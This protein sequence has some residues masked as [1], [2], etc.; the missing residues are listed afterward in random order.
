MDLEALCDSMTLEEQVALLAGA[1]FWTTVPIE[2]VGVPAIK[3]T[4]GP[5]G[6]RGGGALLGG[7]KTACFPVGIALA[8][9]WNVDLVHRIGQA[10]A[11]EAH[12]KGA[13][14][15]LG[16]T[17][18]LH[19]HPLNGRNFECFSEDPLLSARVACAYIEGL[20]S[21][22][23]AATVK[24]YAG[25]ESEF[26]R[27]TINSEIDER[28][29][30]E[31]YLLPFEAAV[32][33]AGT[34]AVMA[35][36]NRLN[37][38]HA[39][40]HPRLLREIL[41][42][43][44]HFDGVVM[45]DWFAT[46]TTAEALNAG[47]DLEMPGPTRFRGQALA[48]AVRAGS[49]DATHLRDGA[50]RILRLIERVGGFADPTIGPE[51]ATD[52]PEHRALI[53]RAGA[54]G[55]VLLKN[56]G[57]LPLDASRVRSVA[58]IGPNAA[59]AQIMGGGSAQVN[60]YY[61]V[62]PLEG[63]R[64][65]FQSAPSVVGY[66]PGCV[67]HRLL[68]LL[69]G[70]VALD[71]FDAETPRGDPV[72][73][74]QRDEAEVMWL[75]TLPDGVTREVFSARLS[76]SFVPPESGEYQFSLVS[77]GLSRLY[78]DGDLLVDNWTGWKP[79]DNY[80]GAGSDE[81]VGS[82]WLDS[83]RE[84]PVVVEYGHRQ[85]GP[86]G[87]KAVR[88]GVELPLGEAAMRQAVD[89]AASSD[90]AV[91]CVGLSGEWD[92]EGRDRSDIRL[93]GRQ[94]ELIRLVAAANSRSVVVLQSGGPLSMPW[95]D[96]VAAVLEAWYPGQECGNAIADVLFGLV[97]PAGRLPQTFPVRLEDNPAAANYPGENGCVR[98][99]EGV[100]VGYRHYQARGIEPLFA[101]GHGLSYTSF[102]YSNLQ[103]AVG[104]TVSVGL[105]VT[106]TGSRSG[107]E[108]VQV[109]VRDVA[110]TLERPPMELKAFAKVTL[111]SGQRQTLNFDLDR[112]ALAFYD[113][114]HAAWHVEAGEFEVLVGAASD[115][116]RLRG[117]FTLNEDAWL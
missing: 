33:Q 112:R 114:S 44:W 46:H 52:R 37:G 5:N 109:Y 32:K 12:S 74:E 99:A 10:L 8:S 13:R 72:S 40:E 110:C 106:N 61:R 82:R 21:Q 51:R 115:D 89:L 92:T 57:V 64:A 96:D 16:P 31:L 4:D 25:N 75:D 66:A 20:Q 65:H 73:S 71:Y 101:F 26:E 45:S 59:V 27:M 81:V 18:N 85:R 94:D 34:W 76:A 22:G 30:R 17:V 116:I 48:A 102:M 105:D 68:P 111:D 29:L 79:G 6:A 97:N 90:V 50:L 23:V 28:T 7:V 100:F 41:K 56:D 69:P 80:F 49:V 3:V 60:A 84:Y 9:T 117:G 63:I 39:A 35:A 70:R 15:L 42:G 104:P 43:E 95:I 67:N 113:A 91:V 98:Y 36:Y 83:G 14:V 77:A 108:V 103:F 11:E 58:V 47:L 2:R 87:L 24:H 62:S 107:Q 19:R 53:R 54:E 93:V 86:F 38:T 55:V 1:D 78:V 88:V